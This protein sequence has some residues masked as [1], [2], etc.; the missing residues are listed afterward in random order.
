MSLLVF[1]NEQSGAELVSAEPF[2]EADRAF[3]TTALKS[4]RFEDGLSGACMVVSHITA[5]AVTTAN[6]GDCRAIVGRRVTLPDGACCVHART[7][8]LPSMLALPVTLPA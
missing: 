6:A 1:L 2:L 7:R 3:L 5:E 8:M 4:K